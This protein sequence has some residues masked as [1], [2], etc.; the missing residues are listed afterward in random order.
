MAARLR[1]LHK[2]ATSERSHYYVG[3][4]AYQAALM[5]ETVAKALADG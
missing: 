5:L 3:S 4:L 1:D 2:Q